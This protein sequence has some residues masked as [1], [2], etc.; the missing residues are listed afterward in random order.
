M[1]L[2]EADAS[3]GDVIACVHPAAVKFIVRRSHPTA[4]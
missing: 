2:N 3:G 4:A 1:D